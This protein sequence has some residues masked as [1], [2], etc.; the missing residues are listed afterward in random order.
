MSA[1]EVRQARPTD[2]ALTL[3]LARTSSLR[4]C[5][6]TRAGGWVRASDHIPQPDSAEVP[7]VHL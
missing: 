7:L 5:R 3:E 4:Y 2:T 6:A 1:A